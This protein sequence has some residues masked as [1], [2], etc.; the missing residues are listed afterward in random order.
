M[1]G[2]PLQLDGFELRQR[3]VGERERSVRPAQVE[4]RAGKGDAP[5][6]DERGNAGSTND[7]KRGKVLRFGPVEDD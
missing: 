1:A 4:R 5:S 2:P 6:L 7:K 3:G